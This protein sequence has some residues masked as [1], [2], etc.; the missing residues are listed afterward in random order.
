MRRILIFC[1]NQ[2]KIG[3]SK[4]IPFWL[5]DFF[6]VENDFM[7]AVKLLW[8]IQKSPKFVQKTCMTMFINTLVNE[9][10]GEKS[11]F[12]QINYIW[13]CFFFSLFRVGFLFDVCELVC[14]SMVQCAFSIGGLHTDKSNNNAMMATTNVIGK[15]NILSRLSTIHI[16][17]C[18]V[19]RLKWVIY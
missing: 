10:Y 16:T 18:C 3:V 1:L 5:N 17:Q 11:F 19:D 6:S 9:I 12:Q 13:G 4:E 14:S 15:C 8:I 2:L 7:N